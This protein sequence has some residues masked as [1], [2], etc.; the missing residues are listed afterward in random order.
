MVTVGFNPSTLKVKYKPDTKKA[1]IGCCG[2]VVT[3][4]EDCD[5]DI[6]DGEVTPKYLSVT[7]SDITTCNGCYEDIYGSFYEY[8]FLDI[9]GEYILE[10]DGADGC[11]WEKTEDITGV[12]V[13]RYFPEDRGGCTGTPTGTVTRNQLKL[14]VTLA[15]DVLSLVVKIPTE[16]KNIFSGS[17]TATSC[18]A[19][20][21]ENDYTEC[22]DDG[23]GTPA[24]HGYGGTT[25][26]VPT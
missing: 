11:K 25:T 12:F 23:F 16:S 17:I 1:C 13:S 2:V 5:S 3:P 7:L 22:G 24:N 19:G 6:C 8:T 15:S 4:G 20:E 10:Q 21:I 26:I 9:N 14:T 18:V